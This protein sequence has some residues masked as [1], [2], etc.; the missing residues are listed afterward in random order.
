MHLKIYRFEHSKTQGNR[1]VQF[2]D[3]EF[4]GFSIECPDQYNIPF[5]SRVLP[6]EYLARKVRSTSH[7]L[8]WVL[9]NVPDR[10][11]I[12]INHKGN[13]K[14][15]FKGCVGIGRTPY[16]DFKGERG[17]THTKATCARFM[18][19]TENIDELK[20]TIIDC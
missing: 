15:N 12:I 3:N 13:S 9:Q 10:T 1:G 19:L 18:G 8:C 2:L 16:G 20:V 14:R 6:G 11:W 17:V 7:G 4:I 5:K